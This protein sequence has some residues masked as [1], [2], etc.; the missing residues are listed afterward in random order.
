MATAVRE[1]NRSAL[2]RP[3]ALVAF[4][5][6]AA[7]IAGCSGSDKYGV[8]LAPT[9]A[10][11]GEKIGAVSCDAGGHDAAYH[12]HAQ[13]AV[14]LPDG[15][16][17]SVPADIG[18]G[19]TCMYWLHTHDATGKLHVEA[20]AATVATLADFLEIWRRS[21]NPTIPDAVAAG[22]AEVRVM[23]E[24]VTD[25]ASIVLTEGLGIEIRVTSFP[26]R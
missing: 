25:P 4:A 5:L 23:G 26:A 10:G 8:P 3:T 2:N 24:V 9:V 7:L 11:F 1:R 6:L 18:V 16:S 14:Y 15:T 12:L 20:P 17:T 21:T 22:L 19:S 13:L